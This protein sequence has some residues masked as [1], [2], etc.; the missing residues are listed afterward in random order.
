MGV[1]STLSATADTVPRTVTLPARC[2]QCGGSMQEHFVAHTVIVRLT[3][4]GCYTLSDAIK[5]R[6]AEVQ[7]GTLLERIC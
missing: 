6:C 5:E 3:P 1:W 4:S 7:A 2:E